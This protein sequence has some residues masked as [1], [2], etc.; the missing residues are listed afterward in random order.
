MFDTDQSAQGLNLS[1]HTQISSPNTRILHKGVR[2][3]KEWL[4]RAQE[5]VGRLCKWLVTSN[6][7][8]RE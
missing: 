6:P 3:H 8:E 7:R 5:V 2:T 4:A 1:A